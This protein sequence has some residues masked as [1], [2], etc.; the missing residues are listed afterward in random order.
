MKTGVSLRGAFFCDEA[1]STFAFGDCFAKNARND[2][3]LSSFIFH[4]SF[5]GGIPFSTTYTHSPYQHPFPSVPS[6]VIL[7][8]G[9][10]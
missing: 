6:I 2:T 5:F 8:K 7:P 3:H 4:L 1:I 10:N 9:M